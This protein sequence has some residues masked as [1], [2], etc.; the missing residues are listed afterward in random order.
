MLER[1][2]EGWRELDKTQRKTIVGIVV[3]ALAGLVII[4]FAIGFLGKS[5]ES[6][7]G[8]NTEIEIVEDHQNQ[9]MVYRLHLLQ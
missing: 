7:Q 4:L 8:N 5:E 3:G 9:M 2:L 1:I 6:N